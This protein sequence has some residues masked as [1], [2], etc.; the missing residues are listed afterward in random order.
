MAK[1]LS[2]EEILGG[3]DYR[4]R[5]PM[6]RL[7]RVDQPTIKI[8][9][10]VPRFDERE[11]GFNRAGRGD[12]GPVAARERP[13]FIPKFPIGAALVNMTTY[14]APVVDGEV[15]LAKAPIPEDPQI[16]S[17]HIKRL[18]YFLRA[19]IVGICELPQYAVYSHS[20]ADNKP[21]ELNHKYAIVILIDQDY[22]T[23]RGSTGRDWIS[24][25]PAF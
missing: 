2:H 11:H 16:L 21:I 14:L 25:I 10:N 19:D 5:F 22:K 8:T 12:F 1:Q 7:K 3:R 6:E 9:D 15:A 24:G 13:H 4:G 20:A 23:M 18:G 17:R